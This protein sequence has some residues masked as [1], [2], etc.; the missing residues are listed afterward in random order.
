[1][2]GST[3]QRRAEPGTTMPANTTGEGREFK[4]REDTSLAQHPPSQHH[5]PSPGTCNSLLTHCGW[6]CLDARC[7]AV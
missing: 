6:P 7:R 4:D 1:M 2:P 3:T 5:A